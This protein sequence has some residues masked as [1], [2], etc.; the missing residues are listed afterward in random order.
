MER[1]EQENE[2][3]R[4]LDS[5]TKREIM[6]SDGMDGLDTPKA[7][8]KVGEGTRSKMIRRPTKK[9]GGLAKM[10]RNGSREARV[11]GKGEGDDDTA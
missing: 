7:R 5:A 1:D 2:F 10:L 6:H 11:A 9:R 4:I 3:G 8:K